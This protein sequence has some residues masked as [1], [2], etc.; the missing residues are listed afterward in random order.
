M[1][2]SEKGCTDNTCQWKL[3]PEYLIY[4]WE[5]FP[6]S[7]LHITSKEKFLGQREIDVVVNK[8]LSE[9]RRKAQDE[10]RIK[11]IH[12]VN[13]ISDYENR[14]KYQACQAVQFQSFQWAL[15]NHT[16]F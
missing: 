14:K 3:K 15:K 12:H 2:T 1:S 10:S 11:C 13:D 4:P 8:R 7:L 9:F 5:D 16:E 6:E